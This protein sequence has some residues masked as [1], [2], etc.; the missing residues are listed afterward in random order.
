M[1][2][3]LILAALVALPWVA[4]VSGGVPPAAPHPVHGF[5]PARLEGLA[6]VMQGSV[7]RKEL[8]GLVLLVARDGKEV[9][10]R[11]LGTQDVEGRRP[12]RP[13]TIFRIASMTKIVTSVATLM[14]MEEGR[15]R[16][17]D[18]LSKFCP[19]FK[20]VQVA[21]PGKAGEA[22]SLKK[23]SRQVTVHDLL[24][25]RAGLSYGF[26]GDGPVQQA[27]R[28][29]GV[30]DGLDDPGITLAENVARLAKAPLVHDP[31]TAFHYGLA[32]DVL[33]RVVEVASG[34]PL[35]AFLE[36]RIFRPLGMVDTG[37][38]VPPEKGSRFAAVATA[39]EGGGIR[40][41][42][43][44]ERFGFLD[45]SPEAG[46]RSG[47][48]Y[49]SGGAGLVSTATDFS[50]FLQLL[51]NGGILGRTRLLAPKTVQLM[52]ASATHDLPPISP[53]R[54]F[55]LGVSVL[56]DLGASR[57]LGTPGMWGWS[58]AYGTTF[59]VDPKERLVA[60]LMTQRNPWGGLN[61][62]GDFQTQVYQALV[63]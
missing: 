50:R 61:W 19:E 54:E 24:T 56:V 2:R 18:P 16:L 26:N 40:P 22:P 51:L 39:A 53:G 55:G 43:D 12:M 38:S 4:T 36:E 58:G 5:D 25:H 11:A 47:K 62:R 60:V 1:P 21:V 6:R 8:P 44:P 30:S 41:L 9:L 29:L 3:R 14:L 37:F 42:R 7:D 13:D 15:L 35:D 46:Y 34:R 23:P 52:T 10:F 63:R 32:S 28:K 33:G 48:R 17:D 45:L 31:G 20:E 57:Q 59:W 49:L 27:Y